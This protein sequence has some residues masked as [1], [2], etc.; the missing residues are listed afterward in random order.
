[1]KTRRLVIRIDE[2]RCNGCGQ[3]VVGCAEGALAIVDGKAKL[4][5]ENFCD[6]LGACLG[7]CPTGALSL[8]YREADPFDEAAVQAHGTS[9]P[10]AAFESGC[11]SAGPSRTPCPGS[12]TF[13]FNQPARPRVDH[14]DNGNGHEASALGHWPIQLHLVYS[15]APQYQGADLLLA[16]DC[17]AFA[18]GAFHQRLLRGR[19][20]AIACPKLDDSDGYLE[21]LA[22]LFQQA[23]PASCVVARMEVPCCAGLTRLA[24]EA[25]N[26]ARSPLT[27]EEVIVSVRGEILRRQEHPSPWATPVRDT[28]DHV[29][30]TGATGAAGKHTTTR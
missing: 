9:S 29:T 7:T 23:R 1:M 6:G 28:P 16:A 2:E 26:A 20:L 13:A 17:T 25:R 18:L 5:R 11:P 21:K 3:C 4:V 15:M 30:P 22:T 19:A 12:A 8:E 27:I 24:V 10:S 14:Q